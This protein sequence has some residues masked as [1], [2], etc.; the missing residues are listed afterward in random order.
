M[1]KPHFFFAGRLSNL[2]YL[3]LEAMRLNYQAKR[4][5][6][7]YRNTPDGIKLF[8]LH[9]LLCFERVMSPIH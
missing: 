4:W 5:A 6:D 2:T 1:V 3:D 7:R 8:R 9:V